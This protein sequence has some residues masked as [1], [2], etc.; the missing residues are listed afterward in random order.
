VTRRD[1]QSRPGV[2]RLGT[3]KTR[4]ATL[5]LVL[6]ASLL[7]GCDAL[8]ARRLVGKWETE[9]TPKRTLDLFADG[10][11]ALR[12]SG[13]GLG[14]VSEILGPERGTWRVES[15]ALVLVKRDE[16]GVETSKKLPISELGSEQAV[17][18]G[19]RWRRLPTQ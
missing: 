6:L 7:G 19:E 18:G 5:C 13:K 16:D 11:Y 12:L 1:A 8:K 15:D 14:F 2:G 10:A 4:H 9:A 17:L 3:Q